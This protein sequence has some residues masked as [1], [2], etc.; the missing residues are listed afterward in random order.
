MN[1]L[2]DTNI[3]IHRETSRIINYD[4]GQLFNWLDKLRYEKF[5]HP[6]TITEIGRHQDPK[7]VKAF[8]IKLD[9]YNKIKYPLDLSIKVQNVSNEID[10]NENDVNDTHL[11]N[12]VYEDVSIR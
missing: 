3:I 6:I 1:A 10:V 5:V 12:E 4:I 2:L 11:L 9:S 7:V 8:S